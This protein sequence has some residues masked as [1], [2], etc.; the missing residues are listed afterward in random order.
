[1]DIS[2][3]GLKRL[4]EANNS[5]AA[6]AAERTGGLLRHRAAMTTATAANTKPV[7]RSEGGFSSPWAK[8][9]W[10]LFDI[11]IGAQKYI[12]SQY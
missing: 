1:M 10:K 6:S 8:L 12:A 11:E 7:L 2:S 3:F 4:T 9:S 5:A